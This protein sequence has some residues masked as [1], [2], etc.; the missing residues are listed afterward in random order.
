MKKM[1]TLLEKAKN[2]PTSVHTGFEPVQEEE[3]ELIRAYLAKEVT[4]SQL[5]RALD[6]KPQ[7]VY[8]WVGSRLVRAH[9]LGQ[10]KIS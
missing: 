1:N 10:L 3:L 2:S 6:V 5:A 4:P 7:R 9:F 8:A